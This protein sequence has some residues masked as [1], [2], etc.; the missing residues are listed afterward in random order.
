M[1]LVVELPATSTT[2]CWAASRA[3]LIGDCSVGT[4]AFS[5]DPSAF[6]S[7]LA[8]S[9]ALGDVG[10]AAFLLQAT[11]TASVQTAAAPNLTKRVM[12]TLPG[13]GPGNTE[14]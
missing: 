1:K 5:V 14:K 11:A 8:C 3:P 2:G 10:L 7:A 12:K 4:V 9:A 6:A 13:N